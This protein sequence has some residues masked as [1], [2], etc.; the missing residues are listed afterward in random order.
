MGN[1]VIRFFC[2]LVQTRAEFWAF[3]WV[4]WWWATKTIGIFSKISFPTPVSFFHPLGFPFYPWK[5]TSVNA[6]RS[7]CSFTHRLHPS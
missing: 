2:Y 3:Y 4:F 1:A 5:N 7:F 6:Y